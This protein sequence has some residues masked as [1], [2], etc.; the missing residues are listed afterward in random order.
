MTSVLSPLFFLFHAGNRVVRLSDEEI[1]FQK[2][3]KLPTKKTWKVCT[4]FAYSYV[5]NVASMLPFPIYV[6]MH[7]VLHCI[8]IT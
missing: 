2:T 5:I 6:T 8:A 1:P 3:K 4:M 7:S